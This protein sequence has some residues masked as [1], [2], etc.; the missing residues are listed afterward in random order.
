MIYTR[1]LT[2][3]LKRNNFFSKYTV[4]NML[5]KTNEEINNIFSVFCKL[6]IFC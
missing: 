3:N 6:S 1:S 2:A 5:M 4:D